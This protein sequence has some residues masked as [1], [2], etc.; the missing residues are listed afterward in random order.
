MRFLT[1]LS[2][3]VNQYRDCFV[4]TDNKVRLLHP[5]EPPQIAD[6]F[7]YSPM[8]E[9]VM[10]HL[11]QSYCRPFPDDLLELYTFANGLDLFRTLR[12]I[13]EE[14]SLPASRLS[15]YGVPIFNDR[16]HLE[17]FNICLEDLSRLPDTPSNWLKFGCFRDIQHGKQINEYDLYVDTDAYKAYQVEREGA[18]L[19]VVGVWDSI[20]DC[21]WNLFEEIQ[22]DKQTLLS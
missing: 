9:P 20:D 8:P 4:Y 3:L 19:S 18:A 1:T 14:I 15:I 11:I 6:H 13:T 10:Q 12:N 21:L 7:I 22:R 16:K 2:Q 5:Q 17:P